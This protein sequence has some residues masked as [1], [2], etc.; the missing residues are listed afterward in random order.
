MLWDSPLGAA[1][2]GSQVSILPVAMSRRCTPAKPLF[3]VQTLPSMFDLCGLTILICAASILR[4]AGSVQNWNCSLFGSNFTIVA[5]YRLPSHRLPS[6][7][8]RRPRLPVGKSIGC[9]ACAEQACRVTQER[10][11]AAHPTDVHPRPAG[12]QAS[13][14]QSLFPRDFMP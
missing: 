6:P 2:N 5:W 13:R 10:T 9:A 12:T 4:S 3:W 1:L 8:A 11:L 7:S 14:R